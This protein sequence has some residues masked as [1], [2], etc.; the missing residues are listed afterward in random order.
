[1]TGTTSSTDTAPAISPQ[2]DAARTT[3]AP[4][5]PSTVVWG[6]CLLGFG[7]LLIAIALGNRFSVFTL[8]II[9]LAGL[10][11]AALLLAALPRPKPKIDVSD[12][13]GANLVE[14]F[15]PTAVEPDRPESAREEG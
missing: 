10:G 3:R 13:A 2:E 9:A 5:R 14:I 11:F 7:I 8:I 6:T 4:M 15:E 12:R 1:M